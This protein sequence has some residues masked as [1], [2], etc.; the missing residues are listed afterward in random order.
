MDTTDPIPHTS[1]QPVARWGTST[2]SGGTNIY[3]SWGNNTTW[4]YS[5]FI[6]NTSNAP[7]T[8]TFG[9]NF[10]DAASLLVDHTRVIYDNTWNDNVTGQ[11]TLSPGMHTV[12][13]RFG[14]GLP[15]VGPNGTGGN[16]GGPAYNAFGVA[17]NTVGDTAETGTWL[18]MG[19]SGPNTAFYA[20]LP[21]AATS[22][23]VMSSN[24]TLDLSGTSVW[25]SLVGLGSLSDASGSPTGH[26]VLLGGNTLETGF[27]NSNAT[28]SGTIVGSGGLIKAGAGTFTLAGVNTYSGSTSVTAGV[29][30]ATRAMALPGY[31]VPGRVNV[32]QGTTL[33]V[34]GGTAGWSG[35]QITSLAGN[36]TWSDSTATLGIDTTAGDFTY[37]G[38]ITQAL[39]LRKLGANT[40]TLIGTNAYSGGTQI[41]AGILNINS[42][43]ALGA[44]SAP[45]TFT[46]NSTLQAGVAGIVLNSSRNLTL[47]NGITAT[48]DT[49]AFNMSI[50]GSIGGQGSLAKAGIG[51]LTI[52]N[53]NT[54]GGVD[55]A[56]NPY[57]IVS[58]HQ[59]AINVSPGGVLTNNTS[60]IDVGDAAGLTG[61]LTMSS[62][63]AIVPL[64]GTGYSGVNVGIYGGRGML[65]LTGN[66][67]LDATAT[68][69]N[70]TSGDWWYNVIDIGLMQ[71]SA[72]TVTVGGTSTLRANNGPFGNQGY[73]AVGDGGTGTLTIQDQGLV[74]TNTFLLGSQ[75]QSRQAGGAG[76]VCLSGNGQLLV[77]NVENVGDSS[78]GTF[79]QSGGTNNS[80]S[81]LD[82]GFNTSASSG[83]YSLSGLGQLLANVENVGDSGMGTFTQSGGTNNVTGYLQLGWLAG[84][85]SGATTSA[86]AAWCRWPTTRTW[87]FPAR[88]PS[89]S[90]AGPTIAATLFSATTPAAAGR[91]TSAARAIC[92]QSVTR[93]SAFPAPGPSRSPAGSTI[94]A[95]ISISATTPAAAA[96]TASAARPVGSRH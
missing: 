22:S 5:G 50:A 18:Q 59:G 41:N 31:N 88:G 1:I 54:F 58:I 47:N 34:Q 14:Q 78:T 17:Y 39:T 33:A 20:A 9:K 87:A 70:S 94:A 68:N 10:D 79:M 86:A 7:V 69:Q 64:G 74:Q 76:S 80:G 51:T 56:G 3:P 44:A 53:T 8:Y 29:L 93:P 66:S 19:A 46:G 84:S 4:G 62:G 15:G 25:G 63:T 52:T 26:Q 92:R 75:Y 42:D 48:I 37:G 43:A 35:A 24:T 32:A 67:L 90:P 12:D 65:S 60:A 40:L 85:G 55:S 89:R 16:N 13:L 61:T 83:T 96:R 57:G 6:D 95:A 77:A 91:T 49:Q 82:L 38:S 27:D 11:I 30:E 36:A 72:G 81:Y 21:G 45:L 28:F 23:V 2:N 71:G 73:I